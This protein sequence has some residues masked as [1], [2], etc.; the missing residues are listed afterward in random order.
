MNTV[1]RVKRYDIEEISYECIKVLMKILMISIALM[2]LSAA[3]RIEVENN[4]EINFIKSGSD[5]RIVEEVNGN[6]L[7]T[8]PI[9]YSDEFLDSKLS[10]GIYTVDTRREDI[11]IKYSNLDIPVKHSVIV[12]NDKA[13]LVVN[14]SFL[15][16]KAVIDSEYIDNTQEVTN[17]M[18]EF[19]NTDEFK[20][21]MF[22]VTMGKTGMYAFILAFILCAIVLIVEKLYCRS[23]KRITF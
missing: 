18:K 13:Y 16:L 22:F 19:M 4:S 3:L 8:I 21:N 5:F 15:I 12:E 7:I 23:K 6:A 20:T 17:G 10:Q 9:E 2:L 14:N 11:K 1:R